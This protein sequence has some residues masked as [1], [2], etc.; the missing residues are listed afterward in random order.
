MAEATHFV[1]IA[2]PIEVVFAFIA[3]GEKRTQWRSGILDIRRP[4]G[5]GVGTTYAQ[6]V[7]GPTGR[8]VAADF[9]ITVFEPNR[10]IARD[11]RN[12]GFRDRRGE[13]LFIDARKLGSMTDR[14]HRE[15]T[16]TD[17]ARVAGTYHAWRSDPDVGEYADVAG[18]CRAAKLDEIR[19]HGHVLTPGRYVGAEAAEEDA[20][21]FDD[22]MRRL[23]ATLREQQAEADRLDELINRNL[24]ELGYGE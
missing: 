10:R 4:S 6:G 1:D 5:E 22:K 20:E 23:V 13:T 24:Q 7:S 16:D 3:D 9:Q 8:R 17:I 21:P 2:K 19:G 14:T 18:F 12:S 15:L 11:K